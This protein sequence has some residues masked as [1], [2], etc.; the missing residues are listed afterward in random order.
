M[1]QKGRGRKHK[2][3]SCGFFTYSAQRRT[4][5]F[6]GKEMRKCLIL[7]AWS[8]PLFGFCVFWFPGCFISTELLKGRLFSWN[9][10]ERAL[11][12]L[13][14]PC[15]RLCPHGLSLPLALVW[16]LCS[17]KSVIPVGLQSLGG[18]ASLLSDMLCPTPVRL[19][20]REKA[21]AWWHPAPSFSEMGSKTQRTQG[22]CPCY[23]DQ[24]AENH[25]FIQLLIIIN[26]NYILI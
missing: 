11:W 6:K 1:T 5:M 26:I 21:Q 23:R 15:H 24:K 8:F 25:Y 19:W 3:M 7:A 2:K 13:G 20:M 17:Y 16:S 4:E 10:K 14:P 9:R 12:S 18:H 22:S